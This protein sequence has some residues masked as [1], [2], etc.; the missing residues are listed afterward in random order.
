MIPELAV[1]PSGGLGSFHFSRNNAPLRL[2]TWKCSVRGV[3]EYALS[4]HA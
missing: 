1:C 3:G 2:W 4:L